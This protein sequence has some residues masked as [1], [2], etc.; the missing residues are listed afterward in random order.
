MSSLNLI[1]KFFFKNPPI[2]RFYAAEKK[3]PT[4]LKR[5]ITTHPLTHFMPHTKQ[6]ER[7]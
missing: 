7:K 5:Y 1:K 4:F 6:V 2:A 3:S